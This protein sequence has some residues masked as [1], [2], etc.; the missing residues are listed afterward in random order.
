MRLDHPDVPGKRHEKSDRQ[1]QQTI[2]HAPRF[3]TSPANGTWCA[4]NRRRSRSQP[5]INLM[6]DHYRDHDQPESSQGQQREAKRKAS[7]DRPEDRT[8]PR[9]APYRFL[10]GALVPTVTEQGPHAPATASVV[11]V[12]SCILKSRLGLNPTSRAA[13]R[14]MP[15]PRQTRPCR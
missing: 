13:T 3:A 1:G 6:Q 14:P 5:Q 9:P 15:P 7:D 2:D 4:G 11:G 8:S 12:A 10:R